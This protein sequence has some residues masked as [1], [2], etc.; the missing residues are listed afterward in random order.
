MGK[1]I[2]IKKNISTGILH[3]DEIYFLCDYEL[4]EPGWYIYVIFVQG[5]LHYQA[6]NLYSFN[7]KTSKS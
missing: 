6:L 5:K 2:N 3:E 1:T 7:I 4:R